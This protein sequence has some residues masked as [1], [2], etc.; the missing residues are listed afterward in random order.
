VLSKEKRDL[1][2]WYRSI[3]PA[4]W[5]AEPGLQVQGQPG[6]H[7][8]LWKLIVYLKKEFLEKEEMSQG[9]DVRA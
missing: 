7:K 4:A 8:T 9:R 5:E 2:W 3:I 6:H 1:A